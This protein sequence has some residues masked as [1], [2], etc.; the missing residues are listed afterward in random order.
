[1]S[2]WMADTLV[3]MPAPFNSSTLVSRVST[4]LDELRKCMHVS[5]HVSILDLRGGLRDTRRGEHGILSHTMRRGDGIECHEPA[6]SVFH[7]RVCA[8]QLRGLSVCMHRTEYRYSVV[9]EW[10]AT[11][12]DVASPDRDAATHPRSLPVV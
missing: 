8:R 9:N 12:C 10:G 2:E 1:M 4:L 7:C 3:A 6:C 11:R 5:Q